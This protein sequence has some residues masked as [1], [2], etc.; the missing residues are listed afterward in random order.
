MQIQRSAKIQYKVSV[1]VNKDVNRLTPALTWHKDQEAIPAAQK[2]SVAEPGTA[3]TDVN[4]ASAAFN[5]DSAAA[6]TDSGRAAS[7]A[8]KWRAVSSAV[9]AV[10]PDARTRAAQ[11]AEECR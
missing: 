8:Q 2:P 6:K 10:S 7:I 9:H 4:G 3:A 1:Y 11:T 5:L